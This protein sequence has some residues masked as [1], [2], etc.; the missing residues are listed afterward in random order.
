MKTIIEG[1]NEERILRIDIGKRFDLS[2]YKPFGDAIARARRDPHIAAIVVDFCGTRLLFDSGK[3][4]LLDMTKRARTLRI[5]LC[6]INASPQIRR[7]LPNINRSK[8]RPRMDNDV[9]RLRAAS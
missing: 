5:P 3:A 1:S 7:Q 4:V 2:A 9:T 8:Y 6:L